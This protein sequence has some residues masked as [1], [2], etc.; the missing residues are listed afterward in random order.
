[1]ATKAVKKP[2]KPKLKSMPKKP[3]ISASITVI[4]NYEKKA[5]AVEAENKKKNAAYTKKVKAYEAV[6][7]KKKSILGRF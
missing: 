1:M 3:A 2:S 4:E 5:A 7:K 6:Q